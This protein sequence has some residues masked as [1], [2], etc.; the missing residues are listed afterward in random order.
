MKKRKI[1]LTG[2]SLQ[3]LHD[4]AKETNRSFEEIIMSAVQQKT[5]SPRE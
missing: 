3:K 5:D 1:E 4:I 2:K